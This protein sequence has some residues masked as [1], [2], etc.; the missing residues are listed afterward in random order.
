MKKVKFAAIGFGLLSISLITSAQVRD[1]GCDTETQQNMLEP[2]SLYQ[3][4]MKQYKATKDVRYCD[5]AYP[6]WKVIVANCP[7]QSK[8]LYI[9]GANI[10]K[11]LIA[12]AKTQ[13]QRDSLVDELMAMYDVRIANYGEAANVTA[14]KAMDLETY[15]KD[16][17]LKDYY[18]LYATA[19]T[20]GQLKPEYV[21]KYMEATIKYVKA[22]YA[23]PTL[24]VDNYD[25]ASDLLE[26]ELR[27]QLDDSTKANQIRMYIAGVET[28]FSPYADCDQLVEIYTKKFEADP[29]NVDLL[30]K[31][32]NI[33]MKKGCTDQTLF[34]QATENLYNLEPS[35]A[36]AF[37]MGQ[38]CVSKKK[39]DEAVKYLSDAGKDLEE[40]SDR[41]KA[42]MLLGMA[43]AGQGSYSAARSSFYKAAEVDPTKGDPYLQI[44]ALYMAHHSSDDGMSGRSAYWAACDKASR[45]KNVDPSVADEANKIIGKCSAAF[46]KKEDAFMLN[47]MNGQSYTVGG[48]IGETT[49]VRTR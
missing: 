17:G 6:Q 46:P 15:R 27:A 32:T 14:M 44:A 11:A 4:S 16:A 1:W 23:E 28:A 38:M 41:Y 45:A 22:G 31:I 12:K 42:Y 39:F 49:T 30:K 9:N 3:E 13:S 29:Q 19:T 21:V 48:W 43:Q 24:V 18:P 33:M 26:N 5:E 25:I 35:P 7:K 47:L 36:T 20:L 2:V 10:L 37:R 34:F 40:Q 8:N